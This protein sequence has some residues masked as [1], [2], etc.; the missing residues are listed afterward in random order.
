MGHNLAVLCC[1]GCG[2]PLS[3]GYVSG[4]RTCDNRRQRRLRRGERFSPTGFPGEAID[5]QT[6]VGR[7]VAH[8]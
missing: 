7:I 4:C 8:A 5:N 3:D 1:R 6:I 2:I